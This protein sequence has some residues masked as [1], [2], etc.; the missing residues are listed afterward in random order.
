MASTKKPRA[1]AKAGAKGAAE[2][3]PPF[4]SLLEE[5]FPRWSD[6]FAANFARE[7]AGAPGEPSMPPWSIGLARKSP[8]CAAL[9]ETRQSALRRR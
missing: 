9:L 7:V 2:A 4:T 3:L 8:A 6:A 1:A 5:A